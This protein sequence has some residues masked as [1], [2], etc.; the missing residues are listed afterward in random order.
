MDVVVTPNEADVASLQR[1]F[2]RLRDEGKKDFVD[3][4]AWTA[5]YVG[6]A[7]AM[8]TE[9]CRERY[10]TLHFTDASMPEILSIASKAGKPPAQ[11]AGYYRWYVERFTRAGDGTKRKQ[12]LN[13]DDNI[14]K[15]V[16]IRRQG[17]SRNT[18]KWMALSARRK[19]ETVRNDLQVIR[20][21]DPLNPSWEFRNSVKWMPRIISDLSG[22]YGSAERQMQRYF[23]RVAR[24]AAQKAA[25][26]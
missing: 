8:K 10:R 18:W 23:E 7:I 24:R 6:D 16:T 19:A 21:R 2:S 20:G 22:V 1:M 26:A 13:R 25:T 14:E 17:Y 12:L 11:I 3:A 4:V 9:I 5:W 15:A